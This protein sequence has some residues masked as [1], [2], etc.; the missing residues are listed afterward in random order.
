[1][2]KKSLAW[3]DDWEKNLSEGYF[4]KTKFFII[5]TVES[6]RIVLNSTIDLVLCLFNNCEFKYVLSA[7]F[8]QD[9]LEVS[10]LNT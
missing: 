8:N 7:K 2:L 1:M 9:S 4:K 6:L 5:N 10:I 3:L